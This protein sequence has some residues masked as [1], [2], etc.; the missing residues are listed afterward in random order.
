MKTIFVFCI[1]A[2]FFVCGCAGKPSELHMRDK[3]NATKPVVFP[4]GT[5]IGGA[6]KEQASKLA[7]IFVDSHNIAMQETDEINKSAQAIQGSTQRI[8]GSTQRIEE[9]NSKIMESS[10]KNLET[11]QKALSAIEQL[12]KNQGTGEITLFYPVGSHQL[13]KSSLEYERLVNFVDSLSKESK[14]RKI[15]FVSIGSASA[16]GPK[17]FNK[18]LAERRSEAPKEIIDQYLVNIPHE[19][20]KVYGVGDLYSPK[21]VPFK[22]HQRYQN[23]RIIAIYETDRIPALPEPIEGR[24]AQK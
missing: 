8:E 24:L 1:V 11:A 9:A 6:S 12:S 20:F 5:M 21:H 7:Q 3:A 4:K 13:R 15:L 23:T 16:F 22:E 14:G 10:Q 2:T 18:K 19:Y 17:K